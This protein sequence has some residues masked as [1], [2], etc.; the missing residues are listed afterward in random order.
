[1]GYR[2]IAAELKAVIMAVRGNKRADVV[3]DLTEVPMAHL[4]A[5]VSDMA[6]VKVQ[7]F[8]F[9][10]ASVPCDTLSRLDPS[11]QRHTNHREYSKDDSVACKQGVTVVTAG[12]REPATEIAECHDRVDRVRWARPRMRR[13]TKTKEGQRTGGINGETPDVMCQPMS[14]QVRYH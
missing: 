14:A 11:K 2:Y 4:F 9:V 13:K 5:A 10:W 1:M 12:T 3:M 6:G 8:K 7:E